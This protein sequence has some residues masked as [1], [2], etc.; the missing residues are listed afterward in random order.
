MK[1]SLIWQKRQH[2]R[3]KGKRSGHRQRRR[4]GRSTD[5]CFISAERVCGQNSGSSRA[6]HGQR[7]RC[8]RFRPLCSAWKHLSSR[9]AEKRRNRQTWRLCGVGWRLANEIFWKLSEMKRRRMKSVSYIHHQISAIKNINSNETQNMRQK[10]NKWKPAN[11]K[12]CK[13]L[14]KPLSEIE[15]S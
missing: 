8:R 2:R 7:R 6:E 11:K 13:E 3:L 5:G 15:N 14:R 9:N 12:L 10:Y 4:H 1:L